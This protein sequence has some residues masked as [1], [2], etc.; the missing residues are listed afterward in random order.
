MEIAIFFFL[1]IDML[2]YTQSKTLRTLNLKIVNPTTLY[3]RFRSKY[4]S[5][6]CLYP[7]TLL[8]SI[9]IGLLRYLES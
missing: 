3:N 2:Y 5:S 4:S 7:K 6:L 1:D 9:L 8:E